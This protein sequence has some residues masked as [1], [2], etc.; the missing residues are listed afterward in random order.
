M[1]HSSLYINIDYIYYTFL[2]HL[3]NSHN[4][5]RLLLEELWLGCVM[6]TNLL[7][8]L[9]KTI[10][11]KT[12]YYTFLHHF[13]CIFLFLQ[14]PKIRMQ[15]RSKLCSTQGGR[16]RTIPL[17]TIGMYCTNTC[18]D[19]ETSTFYTSLITSRI[20]HTGQFWRFQSVPGVPTG[21]K[22]SIFFQVL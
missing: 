15:L 13:W 21:T 22:I 14:A 19:T 5:T 16:Y 18:T 17:G 9:Q 4:S 6:E 2:H 1:D 20:R 7:V 10:V 12:I 3:T 11:Q 8:T